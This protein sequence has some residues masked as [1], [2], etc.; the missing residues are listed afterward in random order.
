MLYTDV[1][2]A[3]HGLSDSEK[4][5]PVQIQISEPDWDDAFRVDT[6]HVPDS[7]LQKAGISLGR[8]YEIFE[9]VLFVEVLYTQIT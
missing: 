2:R 8:D 7:W 9:R 5:L 6:I 4:E 1:Q 3:T